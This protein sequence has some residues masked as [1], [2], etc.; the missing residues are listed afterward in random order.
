MYHFH[1]LILRPEKSSIILLIYLTNDTEKTF[2]IVS[3]QFFYISFI[4][5]LMELNIFIEF[6]LF[7]IYSNNFYSIY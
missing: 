7:V 2:K 6:Q 1:F 5:I 3:E 4:K